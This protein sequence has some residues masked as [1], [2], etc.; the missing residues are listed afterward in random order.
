[1]LRGVL[2]L[3]FK[4]KLIKGEFL[5]VNYH[6][7]SSAIFNLVRFGPPEFSYFLHNMGYKHYRRFRIL[8]EISDYLAG[9]VQNGIAISIKV[10]F[11]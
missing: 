10:M 2:K 5:P 6:Y 4:L 9:V 1:M 8:R 11:I 7:L 3:L